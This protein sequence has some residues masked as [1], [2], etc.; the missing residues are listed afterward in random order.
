MEGEALIIVSII[1]LIGTIIGMA[2]WQ[3]GSMI[4]LMY[5]GDLKQRQYDHNIQLQKL[6][7]THSKALKKLGTKTEGRDLIGQF[8]DLD[9][10][11]VRD[12]LDQVG[13]LGEF[14]DLGELLSSPLIKGILGG[15]SK[16]R[17]GDL[18]EEEEEFTGQV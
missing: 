10:S 9:L 5:R 15:I 2:M 12:I 17:G 14:G 18:G 7:L 1:S 3:R 13:D 4:K 16:K 11:K 6:K 8:K